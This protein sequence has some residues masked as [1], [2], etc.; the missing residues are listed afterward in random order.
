MK[1][2]RYGASGSEKPGVILPDGSRRAV[3]ALTPEF[4]EGFFGSGGLGKLREWVERNGAR[5]PLVP[6]S[7]RLGPPVARPSKIVCVGLNYAKHARESGATVPA[8]PVLFLKS[9]TAASGPNDPVIIP[10]DSQKTDWEV[11]LALVMEK[12]AS[13]VSED[14][15]LDHVAGYMML[16]DVSER[17][18]QMEHGGQWVKGKSADTFAPMGPF[19]ATKDEIPDSANL[20][21]WLKV[22]GMLMQSSNTSDLIF[23]VPFLVSYISRFMTLL[24]GDVISTGTPSGVGL[25]QKPQTYLKPGDVLELGVDGLGTARQQVVAWMVR[26]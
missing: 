18:Y 25:G 9:T 15:A 23:K 12:R 16:N 24:P 8:E 21:L 13:Y 7:E 3:S 1:L 22:N 11:E 6:E 26:R 4:D 20:G 14:E 5:A 2:I 10:R 19:L 17:A